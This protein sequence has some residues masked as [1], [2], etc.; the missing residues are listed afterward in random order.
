MGSISFAGSRL[1]CMVS[2]VCLGFVPACTETLAVASTYGGAQFYLA[3]AQVNVVNGGNGYVS[4]DYHL[5][6]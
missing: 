6:R 4:H 2:R 1:H 5:S 3:C